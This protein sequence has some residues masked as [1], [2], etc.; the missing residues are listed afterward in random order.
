MDSFTYIIRSTSRDLPS[1]SNTCQCNIRLGGL[2]SS[3]KLF[4]CE[5]VDFF[6]GTN[7]G[8]DFNGRFVIDLRADGLDICNGYDTRFRSLKSIAWTNVNATFPQS[9]YTFISN[10]FNG[11]TISF[12]LYNERDEILTT[13]GVTP[14][15]KEWILILKMT[16][17]DNPKNEYYV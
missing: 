6:V 9:T 7:S 8:A 4:L 5:V 11:K 1:A 16:P 13:N 15:N 3:N 10:N 12:S 14:F 17:I 2:P